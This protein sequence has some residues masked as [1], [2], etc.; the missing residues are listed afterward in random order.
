MVSAHAYNPA[1]RVTYPKNLQV[2]QINVKLTQQNEA[3]IGTIL[4]FPT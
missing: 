1:I 2:L 3:F 4:R